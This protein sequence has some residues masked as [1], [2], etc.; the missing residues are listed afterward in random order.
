MGL[1]SIGEKYGALP[2]IKHKPDTCD[3]QPSVNNGIIAFVTG[4]IS[5]DEGQPIKFSQTF[6]LQ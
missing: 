3:F 6:H 5:I 2:S 4:E 1:T